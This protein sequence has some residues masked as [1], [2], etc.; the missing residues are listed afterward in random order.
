LMVCSYGRDITD[1]ISFDCGTYLL[2]VILVNVVLVRW[3]K[4]VQYTLSPK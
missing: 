1:V 3:N 4:T 2:L